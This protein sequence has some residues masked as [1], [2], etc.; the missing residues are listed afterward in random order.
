MQR[1]IDGIV[2]VEVFEIG[3]RVRDAEGGVF[4]SR[5]GGALGENRSVG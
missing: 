5:R 2:A 4:S 3:E 1:Q